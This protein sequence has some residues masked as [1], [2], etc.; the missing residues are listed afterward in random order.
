MDT[1]LVFL[2]QCLLAS[3]PLVLASLGGTL[4]ERAGIANI[5]LEGYLLAGAFAAAVGAL[6]TGSLAVACVCALLMGAL[7]GAVFAVSTVIFRTNAI[8]AGVAINL[9]AAAATRVALKVLYDSASNSPPLVTRAARQGSIGWVTLTE[10]LSQPVVYLAALSV[11]L[12]TV[13]LRRTPWGLRVHAAGEYPTALSARG[14]SVTKV[15]M[16]ALILGGALGGLGG[17]QLSLAQHEFVAYMSAGRGFLAIAAVILG[18][19]RP[20]RVTMAAIAIG[21]LWTLESTLAGRVAVPTAVLQA[22]PFVLTL[23]AVVGVVG[24]VK[25]PK[26]LG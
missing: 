20:E 4:S 2:A 13:M 1:L 3:T 10:T 14:V 7:M 26:A 21:S 15:R 8:V 19:W 6:A 5:A 17:A 9:F 18:G 11:V 25:A 16:S 22:M 23:V 24:R 12:V